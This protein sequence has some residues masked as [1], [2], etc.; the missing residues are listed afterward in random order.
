[1][2]PQHFGIDPADS[3]IQIWINPE[4]WICILDRCKLRLD[5][6]AVVCTL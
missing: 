1:M 4:I 5:A 3:W 2:N 6:L